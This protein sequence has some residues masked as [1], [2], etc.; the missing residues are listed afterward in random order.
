[1]TRVVGEDA[2]GEPLLHPGALQENP[3]LWPLWKKI[4]EAHGPTSSGGDRGLAHWLRLARWCR[5]HVPEEERLA[6]EDGLRALVRGLSDA[7][8]ITGA[9]PRPAWPGEPGGRLSAPLEPPYCLA[10]HQQLVTYECQRFGGLEDIG[11]KGARFLT[12]R[13]PYVFEVR[14]GKPGETVLD[15]RHSADERQAD[16]MWA[17]EGYG[18]LTH[19]ELLGWRS[20]SEFLAAMRSRGVNGGAQDLDQTPRHLWE[21]ALRRPR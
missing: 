8:G 15:R 14:P 6:H 4:E 21:P 12:P 9:G 13:P 1:M 17:Y 11:E 20:A 5:P 18:N 19:D 3:L 2:Q 16:P 10:F 7:H